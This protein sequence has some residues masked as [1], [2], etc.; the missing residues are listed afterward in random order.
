MKRIIIILCALAMVSCATAPLSNRIDELAADV[1]QNYQDYTDEDWELSQDEYELLL[2]EYEEN[3]QNYTKEEKDA[4]NRAIGRY[5][6]LLIKEGIKEAET[7]L[8]EFGE[9][10]PSLIDGFISAFETEE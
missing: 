7:V 2:Q 8:K 9:R 5:N 4:I 1:E 6:G 10:L 3:Y